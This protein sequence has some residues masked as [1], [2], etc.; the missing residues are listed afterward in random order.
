M[1]AT[2]VRTNELSLVQFDFISVRV[3][4]GL[5]S[6]QIYLTTMIDNNLLTDVYILVLI[7][8]VLFIL[9]W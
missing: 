5:I 6:V 3:L 2:N 1:L 9:F 4:L 7:V 8:S